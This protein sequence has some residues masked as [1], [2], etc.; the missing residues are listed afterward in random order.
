[1]DKKITDLQ[2]L[3]EVTGLEY[4][5]VA[6]GANDDNFKIKASN[7]IPDPIEVDKALSETSEN[8]IQNKTVTTEFNKLEQRLTNVEGSSNRVVDINVARVSTKTVDPDEP[9]NVKVIDLGTQNDTKSLAF[10][11]TIPRGESGK[12]GERGPAGGSTRTIFAFKHA[13]EKP[14]RPVGGSWDFETNE[15][16]YPEGWS[17]TD[18]LPAPIW[19][20]TATFDHF[21]IVEDWS[22]PIQTT[23]EDGVNG[24][25]GVNIEFIYKLF[26]DVQ[27]DLDP[28]Y[29]NPYINDYIPEGWLDHP[30]GITEEYKCEYV[31]V[32][33]KNKETQMWGLWSEPTIWSKWGENGKDGDGIEY[34]YQVAWDID[35]VPIMPGKVASSNSPVTDYQE[36]EFIPASA[37][38]EQEW[39]DNPTGVSETF[40]AEFVSTR[41]FKFTT[42]EWGDFSKPV[43]WAKWSTDGQFTSVVFCRTNNTPKAPDDSDGSFVKPVPTGKV[44]SVTG[45][46][47]NMYWSDGI[48]DGT[49]MLWSTQRV[50]T[51]NGKGAQTSWSTP[52]QMTDTADF[53]VEFNDNEEFAGPP[54]TPGVANNDQYGWSDTSSE[55]TIWMATSTCKNGVWSDWNIMKIKGEKGDTGNSMTMLGKI[56][57]LPNANT[58]KGNVG[59]S[60]YVNGV[61][62]VWDGDS[63]RNCGDFTGDPGKTWYIHIKYGTS[64]VP[65]SWTASNGEEPGPFIGICIN[66]YAGDHMVWEDYTWSKFT[67][68][69]GFGYEYI[70]KRTTT[71][72]AP[73]LPT[74]ITEADVAPSGWTDDPTGVDSTY[75]YEWCCYR[76][77]DA[78]GNNAS[79]WIG[80]KDANGNPSNYAWLFAMY[81]ESIPG[82]T[83]QQ[84]P[85]LYPAGEWSAGAR[86]EQDI[87]NIDGVNVVKA[88][89][90][91]L[92]NENYYVL[93]IATS[94]NQIP[95]SSTAWKQ[96]D[97]FDVVYAKILLANNALV[98]KAVFN[99]DYIFSQRGINAKGEA[100]T[101]AE[102]KNFNAE[103]PYLSTN[104]FRP[105]WCVN[106]VTGEMWT[107]TGKC[108]F[109]ADGSGKLA[110]GNITWDSS[111]NLILPPTGVLS[112]T[113]S[114]DY[115]YVNYSISTGSARRGNVIFYFWETDAPSPYKI[116]TISAVSAPASTLNKFSISSELS[117]KTPDAIQMQWHDELLNKT[118]NLFK[119]QCSFPSEY[120]SKIIVSPEIWYS[121]SLQKS[122]LRLPFQIRKADNQFVCGPTFEMNGETYPQQNSIGNTSGKWYSPTV[123]VE[124][125]E[126]FYIDI[127]APYVLETTGTRTTYKINGK[128]SDSFLFE[129]GNDDGQITITLGSQSE[130]AMKF[131]AT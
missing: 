69:D 119:Y 93:D 52:A 6:D 13:E 39:T 65:N 73:E 66:E 33:S 36:R 16:T 125:G 60:Y 79:K 59:D 82:A 92:Y 15:V 7:V 103:N 2:E 120:D 38:G 107:G 105:T 81:A 121:N 14:D 30:E 37:P 31:C 8:P 18:A 10:E 86:Y 104:A 1:M 96:M 43:L 109:A 23:G 111:G 29:S 83:G 106:L 85:I 68:D 97:K 72:N 128:S 100:T 78:S 63:W 12:D 77:I 131:T 87:E 114:G 115:L 3:E 24:T 26:K 41:K 28:P 46:D 35:D 55:K 9:A 17:P 91:V 34:I 98:G 57:T 19:M 122:N 61:L 67:G 50:F 95:S 116:I 118:T 21:G 70:F 25:D 45:Q 124:K 127:F 58:Y 130:P 80:K 4:F 44:L 126:S 5:V 75:K 102:Y 71:F 108:Y 113:K 53:D 11:F 22:D 49:E 56:D 99:G 64:T 74:T 88:T 47:L 112:A 48:P 117:N 40:K 84:G 27:D 89:P 123:T 54:G 129:T 110:N 42:Q 76:T 90:Y 51:W 32:R 101:G 62:Y 94:T 20:S